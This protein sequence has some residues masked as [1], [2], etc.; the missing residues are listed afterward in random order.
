MS[1][2]EPVEPADARRAGAVTRF[3]AFLGDALVVTIWFRTCE[4]LLRAVPRTLGHFAP[5]VNLHAIFVALAPVLIA[6]YNVAFWTVL[7]QTPGKWLMGVKVV[8]VTGGRMTFR[9][10]LV[11]VIGYLL[12]ALPLYLGYLWMLGPQRRG[13]HDLL[14]GTEVTYVRRRQ[15]PKG[16]TAAELRGRI[17]EPV[18][19]PALLPPPRPAKADVPS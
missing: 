3:V 18:R 2:R 8:P 15:A 4:W 19:G 7:S 9:R 1:A 14:A 17:R 13:W 6:V 12:S 11:R 5:P 10:S 16:L